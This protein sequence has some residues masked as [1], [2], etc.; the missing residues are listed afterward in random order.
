VGRGGVAL[1]L[2]IPVVMLL[3]PGYLP[4]P[5]VIALLPFAAVAGAALLDK[6]AVTR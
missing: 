2:L 1:A 5:Y 4:I 6:T 3:R